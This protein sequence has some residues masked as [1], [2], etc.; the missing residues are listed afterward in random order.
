MNECWIYAE[1][2]RKKDWL[3]LYGSVKA[4]ID[5]EN[6]IINGV[7]VEYPRLM[8][9][10]RTNEFSFHDENIYIKKRPVIKTKRNARKLD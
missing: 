7:K 2:R 4:M 10:L 5:N 9:I 8:Y 3:R 6:V 1:K